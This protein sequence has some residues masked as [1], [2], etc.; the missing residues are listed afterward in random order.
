MH[1]ILQVFTALFNLRL[2][3]FSFKECSDL[4]EHVVHRAKVRL[5]RRY[6]GR[7][8]ITGEQ[9]T[10]EVHSA[11]ANLCAP[12]I[13]NTNT[14]L[15]QEGKSRH[16]HRAGKSKSADVTTSKDNSKQYHC[17][18]F[19]LPPLPVRSLLTAAGANST[20]LDGLA[21]LHN[22]TA[23]RTTT[24]CSKL[25]Q[26]YNSKPDEMVVEPKPQVVYLSEKHSNTPK[27]TGIPNAPPVT[28]AGGMLL[29]ALSPAFPAFCIPVYTWGGGGG[30]PAF[31]ILG[32]DGYATS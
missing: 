17:L 16:L 8:H 28:P 4:A 5:K 27:A 22:A 29:L 3:C 13:G 26:L 6:K 18:D 19:R 1:D 14:V 15:V 25:Q 9:N 7:P 32:E 23:S 10:L 2:L 30:F 31:C 12:A 21:Y 11:K 24:A 20:S